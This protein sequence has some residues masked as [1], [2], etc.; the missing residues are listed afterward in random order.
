MAPPEAGQFLECAVAGLVVLQILVVGLYYPRL[1]LRDRVSTINLSKF[2]YTTSW[3]YQLKTFFHLFQWF[4]D[5]L[6]AWLILISTVDTFDRYSLI[7]FGCCGD[8]EMLV[9][10][11]TSVEQAAHVIFGV[12]FAASIFVRMPAANSN[13]KTQ[14]S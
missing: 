6:L 8:S 3:M 12:G 7:G 10:L 5:R 4:Y 13:L 9:V 11:K 14:S 2:R 1:A